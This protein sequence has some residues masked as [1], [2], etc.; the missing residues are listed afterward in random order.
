M[1]K[2]YQIVFFWVGAS[3][4]GGE[5]NRSWSHWEMGERERATKLAL[6]Q[7][8]PRPRAWL[9][10][11][12][13]LTEGPW[14]LL[15]PSLRA[16]SSG[17]RHASYN[18]RA[19]YMIWYRTYIC[20]VLHHS[21]WSRYHVFIMISNVIYWLYVLLDLQQLCFLIAYLLGR[22][23]VQRGRNQWQ[24]QEFSRALVNIIKVNK[25]I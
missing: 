11:L 15:P 21:Q 7:W 18:H 20:T 12:A 5:R 24:T 16:L 2:C 9:S 13:A 8:R 22:I 23:G 17:I 3:R 10:C 1:R 4:A 19:I 6:R 25:F 14:W